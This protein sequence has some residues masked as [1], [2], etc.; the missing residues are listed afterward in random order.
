MYRELAQVKPSE[1]CN[2]KLLRETRQEYLAWA[3]LYGCLPEDLQQELAAI[4]G[5]GPKELFYAGLVN[6]DRPQQ[7]IGKFK[8]AAN[9]FANLNQL[10]NHATKRSNIPVW[11][12]DLWSVL[13][14]VGQY[15]AESVAQKR[16]VLDTEK[17]KKIQNLLTKY[18][19]NELEKSLLGHIGRWTQCQD[20]DALRD[21]FHGFRC[22]IPTQ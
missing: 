12:G 21:W 6:I 8:S 17:V 20:L 3:Y 19:L 22:L 13:P 5:G 16:S 9:A 14:L 4:H 11:Y 18:A 2:Q 7:A 1:Y 10:Q 15:Y